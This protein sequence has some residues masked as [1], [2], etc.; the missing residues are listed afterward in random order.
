MLT[1]TATP[2]GRRAAGR[3]AA[4]WRRGAPKSEADDQTWDKDC[5]RDD[6]YEGQRN[7]HRHCLS[8]N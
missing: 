5:P 7:R 2:F 6:R 3:R 4:D 1:V 8:V